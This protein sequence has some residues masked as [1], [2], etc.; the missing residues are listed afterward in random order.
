MSGGVTF[1]GGSWEG[2]DQHV[3]INWNALYTVKV[4]LI[5]MNDWLWFEN[6]N[7]HAS[8]VYDLFPHKFRGK[9]NPMKS[10]T[11]ALNI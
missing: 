2:H 6:P 7:K 1:E 10:P 9:K 4:G 5:W 8:Q 3:N 11:V